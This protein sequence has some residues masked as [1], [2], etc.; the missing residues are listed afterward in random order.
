L[1]AVRAKKFNPQFVEMFID[2]KPLHR[3]IPISALPSAQYDWDT[4][5]FADGPHKLT[6]VL[7]TPK[8]S[9]VG[10]KS[11]FLST[12]TKKLIRYRLR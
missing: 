8:A 4:K 9:G 5:L 7:P 6:V 11:P 1:I 12:T 10:P 2:D 3:P